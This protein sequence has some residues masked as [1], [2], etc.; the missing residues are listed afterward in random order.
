MSPTALT[1]EQEEIRALAREFA[2]RELRPRTAAWDQG[3][4]LDED[5]FGKLAEVGFLGMTV[6][7]AHGGLGLDPLT[8][9]LV[10][11]ELAW[12]DP[13][14]ALSVGIHN[15]LVAAAIARHGT[16]AQKAAL[17]PALAAG[18]PLGA[19]ALSE[20][21]AGSDVSAVA[22]TA[23]RDG[24][25]W[26]LS[27]AKRWVTNGARAGL[28]VVFARTDAQRLGAFL[29]EPPTPGWT[30][31][32]REVT[33][34]FAAS[35]T[36][37]VALD[38]VGVPADRVLGDPG[39]GFRLALQALDA[40]RVGLAAQAVGIARAALDHALDYAIQREQFDQP[41]ARFGAVQ[42]KLAEM[43][44]RVTGA[45]ALAHGA[46]VRL[47][48]G[49][50][51]RGGPDGLT[52]WSAMAKLTASEAAAW[53]ADEAVQIFGGYGYMRD[54]PVE[55]LMRDAKGTEILEGTSEILRVV[56]ARE[57][58]RDVSSNRSSNH[59]RRET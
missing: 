22:T 34:G 29:V 39:A 49:P 51:R 12:G 26:R 28:V 42:E 54:Y 44:R 2:E 23:T 18:E 9:V 5:V 31:G 17:L 21:Q 52:A 20:P 11:E 45:R 7:E 25:G 6:P 19:F 24:D 8:Y 4:A 55:K 15:G 38:G 1:A 50:E 10:L 48:G 13:A 40:G 14:A 58:L 57:L 27:G 56:I 37:S 41:I 43:A 32:R 16:D 30:V 35:E 33:M 3:R 47:Q 53:V 46:A 36:V 59:D